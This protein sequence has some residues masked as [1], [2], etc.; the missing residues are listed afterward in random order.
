[1]GVG[2]G[3]EL[4]VVFGLSCCCMRSIGSSMLVY[5]IFSRSSTCRCCCVARRSRL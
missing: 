2:V 5:T 3:T 4:A 1:M